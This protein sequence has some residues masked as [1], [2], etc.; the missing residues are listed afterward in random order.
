MKTPQKMPDY[1]SKDIPGAINHL[2]LQLAACIPCSHMAF[3]EVLQ[4]LRS[5]CHNTLRPNWECVCF[6]HSPIQ[7]PS[8]FIKDSSHN[9][10]A[11]FEV[12]E[13]AADPSTDFL[14]SYT[15]PFLP[16]MLAGLSYF[17]LCLLWVHLL[18]HLPGV[19]G[20][21]LWHNWPTLT[22]RAARI[23][24]LMQGVYC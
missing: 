3:P 17:Y 23:S 19:L 24:L 8:I 9:R 1:Q 2:D 5:L 14:F 12:W 4:R 7:F 6:F 11:P 21:Y 18:S 15:V 22:H 13:A 10:T 16:Q 20:G